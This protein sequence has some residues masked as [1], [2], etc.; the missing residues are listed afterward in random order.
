MKERMNL[1]SQSGILLAVNS[2]ISEQ[3]RTM[4]R[5][6]E[7]DAVQTSHRRDKSSRAG[8][9]S[10]GKWKERHLDNMEKRSEIARCV[11]DSQHRFWLLAAEI[12]CSSCDGGVGAACAPHSTQSTAPW[13][14]WR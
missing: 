7:R 2:L 9:S 13:R 12:S 6:S 3:A 8:T 14:E 4:L 11:E 5:F 1:L 10:H